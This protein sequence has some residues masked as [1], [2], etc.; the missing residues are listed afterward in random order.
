MKTIAVFGSSL[1]KPGEPDY[2]SAEAMGRALGQAGYTVMTGGYM[3]VME[4]A[5]RG[6]CEAGGHVI[7]VTCAQIESFRPSRAN[8]WVKEEIKYPTLDGRLKHL[9]TRADG[10]VVMPGGVGTF[11]E[12]LMAWALMR[13]REVSV[14]PLVCFGKFW[15]AV[16]SEFMTYDY[17]PA[18]HKPCSGLRTRRSISRR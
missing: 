4:A 13:V 15:S 11:N 2:S 18:E 8:A 1:P 12:L 17:V 7:G 3:G 9:I 5:S 10:W 6:A 16:L 14:R